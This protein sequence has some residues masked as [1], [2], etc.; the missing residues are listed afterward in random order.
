M[1]LNPVSALPDMQVRPGALCGLR[2]VE[3]LQCWG[4]S[5][6][7]HTRSACVA[8]KPAQGYRNPPNS[9]PWG[10]L[11]RPRGPLEPKQSRDQPLPVT[12]VSASVSCSAKW[13]ATRKSHFRESERAHQVLGTQGAAGEAGTP[14]AC[15]RC[16]RLLLPSPG[17]ETEGIARPCQ[18]SPPPWLR[19][20]KY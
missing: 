19:K 2:S 12:P 17:K 14:P 20:R 3:S 5:P 13:A 4:W 15:R 16:R 11:G 10:G 7:P 18:P 6:G 1:D 9:H 8:W